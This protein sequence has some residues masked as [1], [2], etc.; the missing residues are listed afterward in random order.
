MQEYARLLDNIKNKFGETYPVYKTQTEHVLA[1]HLGLAEN[2]QKTVDALVKMIE[3]NGCKIQTGFVGTPYILHVLSD[4]GYE[5]L[6]YTLLLRKE[7][8]SWLYS[9]GKGETTI[10]EHWDGIMENGNFWSEDMNSF[11]HYAYGSVLDW[12]YEKAAGIQ[13]IEE[14]PGFEKVK[15]IPKP[16]RRLDWLE[17]SIDTRNGK[18]ESRWTIKGDVIKYE[19]SSAVPAQIT[20]DK[21]IYDVEPGNYILWGVVGKV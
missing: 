3:E 1:V 7:Y 8:P 16:D 10:W 18:I 12:V 2:P 6:A 21:K 11:N 13:L 20:I 9:V 17:A 5:E 15:I 14:C 19:I 4:Y